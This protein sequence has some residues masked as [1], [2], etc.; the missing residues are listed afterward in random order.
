MFFPDSPRKLFKG[1]KE[2]RNKKTAGNQPGSFHIIGN[3]YQ[4]PLDIHFLMRACGVV[5]LRRAPAAIPMGRPVYDHVWFTKAF[6]PEVSGQFPGSVKARE[7]S[8]PYQP[9]GLRENWPGSPNSRV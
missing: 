1:S 3:A 6:R 2:M 8:D 5:Q 4:S 9:G 7:G